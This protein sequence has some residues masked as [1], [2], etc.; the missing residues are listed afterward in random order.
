MSGRAALRAV[1][2][3]LAIAGCTGGERSFAVV[4]VRA[5]GAEFAGV[6]QLLV[7][8]STTV[9]RRSDHLFPREPK[10]VFGFSS[11]QPIDFSLSFSAGIN[12]TLTIG[13]Q[14]LDAMSRSMGYG[15]ATAVI[16]PGHTINL[17]VV[18][19]HGRQP[20]GPG[21]VDAGA[22]AGNACQPSDPGTCGAGKTCN[23]AC[24]GT[25]PAALCGS[26]GAARA[27]EACMTTSDC[28]TGTQCLPLGCA[29]ICMRACARDSDCPDGRCAR[30]IPCGGLP[31]EYRV[32][33]AACDPR[34]DAT[35]GCA[36]GLYCQFFD[37]TTT[38]CDCRPAGATG[39]D[40][41]PCDD[42]GDCRPGLV[43]ARAGGQVAC[44]PLCK[45]GGTDCAADRVCTA[46]RDPRW[47]ACLPVP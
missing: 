7:R 29:R 23:V 38:T 1:L 35:G 11:S 22:D 17:D 43:C 5:M 12:G 45:P 4:K 41:A 47:G 9:E 24:F 30:A 6:T 36:A 26:A 13:V 40:G 27:G 31:T 37:E 16:D 10:G 8:A 19:E 21:E 20:P 28:V 15:Q 32:C 33:T 2:G 14:P 46:L 44:R 34:G 39:E 42:F 25:R 3:V 18:V